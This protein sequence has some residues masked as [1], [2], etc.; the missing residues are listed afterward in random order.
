MLA[1][2]NSEKGADRPASCHLSSS[3]TTAYQCRVT[4]QP[5]VTETETSAVCCILPPC[6]AAGCITPDH[7]ILP[8][9]IYRPCVIFI[10]L[11]VAIHISLVQTIT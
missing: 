1:S 8:A 6:L 11:D 4:A 10:A 7:A 9:E 3:Q 2:V 5:F